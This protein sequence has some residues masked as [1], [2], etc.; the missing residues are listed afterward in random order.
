MGVGGSFGQYAFGLPVFIIT[1]LKLNSSF[2]NR[3]PPK[4]NGKGTLHRF[5]FHYDPMS[6]WTDLS[7]E[8]LHPGYEHQHSVKVLTGRAN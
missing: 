1:L 8:L 7:A 6:Q 4:T 5:L 2:K 3:N